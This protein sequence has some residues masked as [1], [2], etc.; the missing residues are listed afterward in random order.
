MR[1]KVAVLYKKVDITDNH[2][3]T[4][5]LFLISCLGLWTTI[6]WLATCRTLF[7]DEKLDRNSEET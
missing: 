3:S 1:L 4:F 7:L 2:E 5:F 6:C